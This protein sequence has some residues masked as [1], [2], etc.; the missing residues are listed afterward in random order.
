MDI[1][2]TTEALS[3]PLK[4]ITDAELD[5]IIKVPL[6]MWPTNPRNFTELSILEE[7][8]R[9]TDATKITYEDVLKDVMAIDTLKWLFS[10]G[11]RV[12]KNLDMLGQDDVQEYVRKL[13]PIVQKKIKQYRKEN[14]LQ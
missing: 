13:E 12:H 1:Q 4:D 6:P 2:E 3:K 10:M 8:R 7:K 11:P 5:W 14:N 9:R